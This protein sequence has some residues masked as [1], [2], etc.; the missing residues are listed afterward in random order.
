[1]N[2]KGKSLRGIYDSDLFPDAEIDLWGVGHLYISSSAVHFNRMLHPLE[3]IEDKEQIITYPF[4]EFNG[5]SL[6]S[7]KAEVNTIHKRGGWLPLQIC[8]ALFGR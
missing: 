5:T 7:L 2:R 1:M 3:N 8:N 4:P 6:E